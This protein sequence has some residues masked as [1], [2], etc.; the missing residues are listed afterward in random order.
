MKTNK[1]KLIAIFAFLG[2]MLTSCSDDDNPQPTPDN[3]IT[4]IASR[5]P[6]LSILVQALTRAG[7]AD[8]LQNNNAQ[9]TAF[10]PNNAAFTAFFQSIS[11]TTTVDNVDLPTLTKVLLNHV[12]ASEIKSANV[13]TAG[14]VSTLS[15]FSSAAN[16]PT[17]SMFVQKS[18][19]DVFIN[20][21]TATTGVKVIAADVDA[22]NGVVHVVN[23]VIAIPTIVDHVVANPEF[24]TLQ[25]VVTSTSGTFGNQSAVLN[26]LSNLTSA[27][28][29]TLFAPNNTA[30]TNA[31]TG[32]G[33]LTGSNV[34]AANVTKTLQ[35]HATAAGNVRSSALMNNQSVQMITNPQQ[36]TTV[37]L[38]TNTVDIRDTANNLSRV[39]QADIQCSNGVI[40]AVNRVLQP[41]F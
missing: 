34:T 39:I 15:P 6:D 4:G 7:L 37:I 3:T 17:I 29:A 14:Y 22:S 40:H 38:G 28:P 16:S 10:A 9:L 11:P 5:T 24:D 8:D 13:P 19:S 33:F 2:L 27:A 23:R 41:T 32:T 35:Y 36:N 18:G 21:G 20:G 26:I 25:A 1:T 30:F 12:I 31:T